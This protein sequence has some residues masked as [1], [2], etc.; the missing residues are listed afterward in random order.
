[1][2]NALFWLG[3]NIGMS[4]DTG[5]VHIRLADSLGAQFDVS[6]VE[7]V[8]L[9]DQLDPAGRS[10]LQQAMQFIADGGRINPK[11]LA[12]WSAAGSAIAEAFTISAR[13]GVQ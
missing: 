3:D 4:D 11:D 2:A 6:M 1:M 10:R 12:A 13:G 5:R 8:A 7:A 9:A